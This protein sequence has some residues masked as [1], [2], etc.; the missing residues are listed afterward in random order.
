MTLHKY[1]GFANDPNDKTDP[2]GNQIS[3]DGGAF[4]SEMVSSTYTDQVKVPSAEAEYVFLGETVLDESYI[5]EGHTSK[6]MKPMTLVHTF[7]V[8]TTNPDFKGTG[9]GDYLEASRTA[10]WKVHELFYSSKNG[11][12][13]V[14]RTNPTAQLI[15]PPNGNAE[16]LW[17]SITSV[18]LDYPQDSA[19]YDP[20]ITVPANEIPD[21]VKE[22]IN[23]P[24]GTGFNSNSFTGT[25]VRHVGLGIKPKALALGW[26]KQMW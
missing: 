4:Y 5:P 22:T 16:S 24:L 9:P 7:L 10:N 6:D 14:G 1:A 17:S 15:T 23:F 18:A 26:N 21:V 20:S 11:A 13:Y 3:V 12:T 2:S 8:E 19:N 25:I